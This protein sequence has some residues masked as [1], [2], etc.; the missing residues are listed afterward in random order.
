MAQLVPPTVDQPPRMPLTLLVLVLAM[1]LPLKFSMPP[2][3][4][5]RLP[6]RRMEVPLR[7]LMLF[8]PVEMVVPETISSSEPPTIT[9]A[10]PRRPPPSVR[11]PVSESLEVLLTV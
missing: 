1:S 3:C 8:S 4:T 10:P 7:R 9:M 2:F 5:L 11:E 6:S